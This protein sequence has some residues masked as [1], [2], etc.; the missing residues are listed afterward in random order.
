MA[1]G[2]ATLL[3]AVFQCSPIQAAWKKTIPYN[4]CFDLQKYLLGTNVVNNVLDFSVLS[5]PIPMVWNM[6]NLS[7][8]RKA[9]ITG[10]FLIGT[11]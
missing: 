3:A 5:L 4:Y 6:M 7:I 9:A 11:L 10:I 8:R 1:W 2:I